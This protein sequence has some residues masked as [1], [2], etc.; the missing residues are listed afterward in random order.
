M[1]LVRPGEGSERVVVKKSVR[2]HQ[3]CFQSAWD[4]TDRG[5]GNREKRRT[6]ILK[7]GLSE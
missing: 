1:A 3:M 6:I 2:W 5:K 4:L 7:R